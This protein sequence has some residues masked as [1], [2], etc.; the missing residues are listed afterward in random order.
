MSRAPGFFM[1]HKDTE[2]YYCF[3]QS[4]YDQDSSSD[5]DNDIGNRMFYWYTTCDDLS[6]DTLFAFDVRDLPKLPKRSSESPE[7]HEA[8]IRN[9][10]DKGLIKLFNAF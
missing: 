10:L 2:V 5:E 8:I 9:A 6:Q 1:E 7:D 3:E 4:T